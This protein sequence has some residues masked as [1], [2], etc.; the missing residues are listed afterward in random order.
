MFKQFLPALRV[1]I[2]LALLTGIIFPLLVTGIAQ[3]VFPKKANGS[4]VRSPD[5]TILGSKLIGQNF[6]Q[7]KYFHPRPSAAGLGYAG[8]ASG[9]TN[10]GPTSNKLINGTPADPKTKTDAFPGIKQLAEAYRKE[11]GLGT[12]AIVPVD[13]VTRSASGL[14][15]DISQANAFLQAS[16]VAKARNMSTD[17]IIA[18]VIRDKKERDLMVLGEPRINV[19]QLNLALD[20]AAQNRISK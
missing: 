3:V 6:T 15:P 5:G 13:A 18:F 11:N 7:A 14:D 12:N 16:R 10:L 20:A 19:L 4:L 2:V 17:Q 9:G 1:T 8:E